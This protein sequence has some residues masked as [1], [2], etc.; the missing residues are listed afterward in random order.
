M[1]FKNWE[2]EK[3]AKSSRNKNVK[4]SNSDVFNFKIVKC[5][6][7]VQTKYLGEI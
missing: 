4:I 2:H 6:M 7:H 3:S 1:Q 5:L